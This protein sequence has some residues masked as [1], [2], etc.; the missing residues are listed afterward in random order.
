MGGEG[1]E[2]VGRIIKMAD[3]GEVTTHREEVTICGGYWLS[4]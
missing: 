2:G 4:Q 1:G 3:N